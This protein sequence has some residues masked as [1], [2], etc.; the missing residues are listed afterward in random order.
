MNRAGS[1]ACH[2]GPDARANESKCHGHAEHN[3]K[4]AERSIDQPQSYRWKQNRGAALNPAV[5]TGSFAAL[6]L[7]RARGEQSIAS[8]V[9]SRPPYAAKGVS[10]HGR[11]DQGDETNED[12]D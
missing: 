12:A 3:S 8:G 2:H 7:R 10:Q 6:S 1:V 4:A 11:F 9:Q 5:I